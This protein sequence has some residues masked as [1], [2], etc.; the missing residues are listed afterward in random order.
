MLEEVLRRLASSGEGALKADLLHA[1]ATL[2]NGANIPEL[3]K[4]LGECLRQRVEQ[5][6][7]PMAEVLDA[8]FRGR[9]KVRSGS[10][11]CVTG[12][13]PDAFVQRRSQVI[14]EIRGKSIVRSRALRVWSADPWSIE[15]RWFADHDSRTP[16]A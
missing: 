10:V 13:G 6:G 16:V 8:R 14:C 11:S 15:G 2:S 12:A 3:G 5:A 4:R 1:T 7:I 9:I